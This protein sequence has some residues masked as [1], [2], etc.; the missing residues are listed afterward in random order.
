[1]ASPQ[2]GKDRGG[3][4]PVAEDNTFSERLDLLSQELERR[5][6]ADKIISGRFARAY[7]D[8]ILSERHGGGLGIAQAQSFTMMREPRLYALWSDWLMQCLARHLETRHEP[9]LSMIHHAAVGLWLAVF[10][11]DAASVTNEVELRHRML[12]LLPW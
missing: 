8:L 1:M 9:Q 2:V 10:M 3:I 6:S 12:R 7:V 5:M 4:G 11:A